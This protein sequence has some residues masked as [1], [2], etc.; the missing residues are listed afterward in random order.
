MTV[1]GRMVRDYAGNAE[2]LGTELQKT[3]AGKYGVARST[4][5]KARDEAITKLRQTPAQPRH[6]PA[7]RQL[8]TRNR[9][10]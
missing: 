10:Q 9:K 2:K 3:L 5:V 4:A 1:V 6:N 7:N 8:A